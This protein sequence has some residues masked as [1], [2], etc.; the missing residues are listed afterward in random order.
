MPE[1]DDQNTQYTLSL[2]NSKE[3]LVINMRLERHDI[4]KYL[5]V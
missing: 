2:G 3:Y 5:I 1:E 4:R